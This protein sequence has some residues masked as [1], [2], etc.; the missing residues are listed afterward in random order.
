MEY[1]NAR[2]IAKPQTGKKSQFKP[3]KV[4]PYLMQEG[5]VRRG[6]KCNLFAI[7]F[8]SAIAQLHGGCIEMNLNYDVFCDALRTPSISQNIEA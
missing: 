6:H 2:F 4:T 8:L 3:I 7:S 1:K 5:G